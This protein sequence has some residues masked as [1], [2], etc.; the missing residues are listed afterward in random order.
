MSIDWIIGMGQRAGK[1]MSGN[2][3]VKDALARG[4][5]KL[6][7]IAKDTSGRTRRELSVLAGSKNIPTVSFGSKVELGRLIGK[8]PRS[9]V[10]FTDELLARRIL[11]ALERGDVDRI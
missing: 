5:V 6:L 10:A 7:V 11:G 9:A 1:L 3:A 2:F 4:R 8:A